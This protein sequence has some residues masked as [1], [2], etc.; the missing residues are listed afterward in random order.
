ML[1][2]EEQRALAFNLSLKRKAE[3]CKSRASL[4]KGQPA[5]LKGLTDRVI[6]VTREQN[7]EQK[8]KVRYDEQ[9]DEITC[10]GDAANGVPSGT[11]SRSR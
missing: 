4:L 2:T 6:A 10:K 8:Q 3:A 5:E 1:T 7:D 9:Y 11:A